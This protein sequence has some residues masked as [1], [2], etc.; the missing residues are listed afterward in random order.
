VRGS[1]EIVVGGLL[2]V[3]KVLVEAVKVP[4]EALRL[5]YKGRESV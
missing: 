5:L 1:R 2:E 4:I 3:R